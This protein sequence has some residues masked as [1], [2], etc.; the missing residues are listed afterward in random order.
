MITVH[1]FAKLIYLLCVHFFK[2]LFS[3]LPRPPDLPTPSPGPLAPTQ[4][5]FC[6]RVS[7]TPKPAASRGEGSKV[8][9][10]RPGPQPWSVFHLP[11]SAPP[12]L[13]VTPSLPRG[14]RVELTDLIAL[15]IFNCHLTGENHSCPTPP[16]AVPTHPVPRAAV[17]NS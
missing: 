1:R 14:L 9:T 6:W 17:E 10:P 12:H 5:G 15:S 4:R 7:P 3:G 13:P 2:R 11:C 8:R 16:Y